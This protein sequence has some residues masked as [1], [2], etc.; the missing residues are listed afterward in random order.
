MLD[1]AQVQEIIKDDK[2]FT[3]SNL[4]YVF[5]K[6]AKQNVTTGDTKMLSAME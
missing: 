3:E 5:I 2:Y 6:Q 4:K 1:N